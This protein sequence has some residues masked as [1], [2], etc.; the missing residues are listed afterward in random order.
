MPQVRK[1]A[2]LRVVAEHRVDGCERSL[3]RRGGIINGKH[4]VQRV[5]AKG[6]V[7]VGGLTEYFDRHWRRNR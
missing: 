5:N 1:S 6:Q 7:I 2:G 3:R 4:H